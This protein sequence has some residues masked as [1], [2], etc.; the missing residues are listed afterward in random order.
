MAGIYVRSGGNW[1]LIQQPH[2]R[3]S[4]TWTPVRRVWVKDSNIWKVSFLSPEE[5]INIL[6]RNV[7]GNSQAGYRLLGTGTAQTQRNNNAWSSIGG[8]W[9][10][11]PYEGRTYNVRATRT[12]GTSNPTSGPLNSWV[13]MNSA[14]WSLTANFGQIRTCQLLLEIRD[15]A[16]EIVRGS[17]TITLSAE[18]GA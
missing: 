2:I 18:N 14:E 13:S 9:R 10:P 5:E 7:Q 11:I 1:V 3:V 8:Q 6:A 17:A 4:G 15:V 12:G 16:D